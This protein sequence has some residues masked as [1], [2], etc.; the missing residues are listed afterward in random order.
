MVDR[1]Q[2]HVERIHSVYYLWSVSCDHQS[3]GR[4]SHGRSGR[5][6]RSGGSC[7]Y[8]WLSEFQSGDYVFYLSDFDYPGSAHSVFRRLDLQEIEIK[9]TGIEAGESLLLDNI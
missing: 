5:S 3:V 4:N 9:T 2:G 8:I 1:I 7:P 6:R